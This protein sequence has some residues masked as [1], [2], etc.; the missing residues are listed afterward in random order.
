[1][2][3]SKAKMNF[4]LRARP[5]KNTSLR[6]ASAGV[7]VLFVFVFAL[8]G[9]FPSV[10]DDIAIQIAKPFWRG[11]EL[12][13]GAI[14]NNDFLDSKRSLVLENKLLQEENQTL[15]E[16]INEVDILRADNQVFRT[17]LGQSHTLSLSAY[18]VLVH[19]SQTPYDIL[20]LDAR[21]KEKPPVGALAVSGSVAVGTVVEV[22]ET[23]IKVDMYSSYNR[24]TE[25]RILPD[26]EPLVLVGRGGGNF[27]VKVPR[28][29]NVPV[30]ALIV[31]PGDPAFALGRI[32]DVEESEKDTFKKVR[33]ISSKN[34]FSLRWIE[35]VK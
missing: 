20:V 24:E 7:L 33:I 32:A 13:A 27:T 16:R 15:R 12:V 2:F 21:E 23:F 4:P 19:P 26:G 8:Q 5:K 10:W 28:D 30:G 22:G 11:R 29:M 3:L 31:L 17:A 9:F 25:G 14:F 34:I 6:K 1:M 18:P 35:I